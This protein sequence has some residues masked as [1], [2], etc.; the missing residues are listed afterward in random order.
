MPKK[1]Y[2][3]N[4]ITRTI[5]E[6]SK[7]TGIEYNK[8]NQRVK[9]NIS[10]EI[11]FNEKIPKREYQLKI[12][13]HRIKNNKNDVIWTRLAK[14]C[15][16]IGCNCMICNVIPQDIKLQCQMKRKVLELVRLYG[17]PERV[18]NDRQNIMD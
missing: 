13:S 10:P 16:S 1:T 2:T 14:E 7:I 5:A 18:E 4:G 9:L 17:K 8:L 12:R 15:Y 3:H 11:I 6:W